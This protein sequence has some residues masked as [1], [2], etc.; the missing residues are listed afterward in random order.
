MTIPTPIIFNQLLISMNLYD[1]AKKQA[2]S[3]F[4]CRDTVDFTIL[5]SYWPAGFWPVSQ[6]PKL[7]KI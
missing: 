4:Y 3:S 6:V 5:Q 1:H 2:F 7:F